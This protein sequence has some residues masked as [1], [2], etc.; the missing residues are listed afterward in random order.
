[1]KIL[2]LNVNSYS[3]FYGQLV[4]PFG[5]ASLG[6]YV[7][8]QGYTIK[9]IEMNSPP[10]RIPTRYLNVDQEL[11]KEIT[12]YS[13]D[14]IA[15]SSYASNMYNI[16]FWAE[17]IKKALPHVCIVVGGNHASYI[18]REI[19]EKCSAIDIVARFEGEIP[20]KMICRSVHENNYDYS[21]IPNIVHRKG[22]EIVEN[23]LL[24]LIEDINLL[25]A[26]NRKYFESPTE[27]Q[28][29]THVD[30]ITARGCP[31]HCTFCDCNHYWKKTYRARNV[32]VVID[33]LKQ[34]CQECPSLKTTRFRD[35][36]LTINKSRCI[37]MCKEIVKNNIRLKFQAHSRLDGLDDEE[38]VKHLSKA[39]FE[40]LFIGL[41]SGS[42]DV[43]VRLKKGIDI[44]KA[45]E[46][47]ALLRSYGIK[48]RTSFLIA[49][50]DETL[51]ESLQTVKLIKKLKL[52]K[53]EFYI[54]NSIQIYPGTYEHNKFLEANPD[55][56]CI[57]TSYNFK[58]KYFGDKDPYGNI[59]QPSFRE[60]GWYKVFLI[61]LMVGPVFA[62][63]SFV[64]LIMGRIFKNKL[65]FSK[66]G[67][68]LIRLLIY[69]GS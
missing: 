30:I 16:L 37:Q 10:D 8:D 61:Y 68:K 11:L 12:E 22:G 51:R 9:G 62:I 2:L 49:T 52:K 20:F 28:S 64:R 32:E 42:R 65:V 54:G 25:P 58:G 18:A 56:E 44:S 5:L 14:I 13:P 43:L 38:V 35:E 41:E 53:D 17:V 36:S 31:F 50:R 39:G 27:K 40:R 29:V 24:E 67:T 6:S 3:F 47:I 26:I 4:I 69:R 34:L 63:R 59:I 46:T 1:M 45:E 7:E 19:L 57:T 55:Y 15:M 60:Y 66:L 21:K 23:E 48:P 33:E